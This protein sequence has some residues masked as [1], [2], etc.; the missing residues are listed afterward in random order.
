M[1]TVVLYTGDT[2]L[3]KQIPTLWHQRRCSQFYLGL[4]VGVLGVLG[5]GECQKVSEGDSF[6]ELSRESLTA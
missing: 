3:M 1:R 4:S 6:L 5:V 2:R